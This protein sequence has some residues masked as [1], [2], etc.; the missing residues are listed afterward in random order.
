MSQMFA[1][2]KL[3]GMARKVKPAGLRQRETEL[4]GSDTRNPRRCADLNYSN[5]PVRTRMPGGVGGARSGYLTAPIPIIVI[6]SLADCCGIATRLLPVLVLP[7]A[8]AFQYAD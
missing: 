1:V 5:C 3:A 7:V 8:S 2:A 4:G 6:S